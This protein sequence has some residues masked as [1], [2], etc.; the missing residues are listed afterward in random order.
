M[1]QNSVNFAHALFS[2]RFNFGQRFP[3]IQSNQSQ[4]IEV[5]KDKYKSRIACS[6]IKLMKRSGEYTK[7]E[8]NGD[9]V[10]KILTEM[11]LI[12]IVYSRSIWNYP[13]RQNA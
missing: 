13:H 2:T 12:K 5:S 6:D 4:K 11:D 7:Y 8:I 10:D 1:M 9:H 3:T